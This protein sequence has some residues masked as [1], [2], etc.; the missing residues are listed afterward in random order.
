M[1]DAYAQMQS[2]PNAFYVQPQFSAEH[3]ASSFPA[4]FADPNAYYHQHGMAPATLAPSLAG[5]AG[6]GTSGSSS[7]AGAQ[8]GPGRLKWSR[9]AL[10]ILG[11][12]VV[13]FGVVSL[14]NT[15]KA[16]SDRAH[17]AV[18][19]T[20]NAATGLAAGG[21]GPALKIKPP[22]SA[23]TGIAVTPAGGAHHGSAAARMHRSMARMPGMPGMSGTH[24]RVR[25]RH[26]ALVRGGGAAGGASALGTRRGLRG[27]SATSLPY[28]GA[29]SWVAALIG[30]LALAAGVF[31]QYKALAIGETAAMYRRGPLLRPFWLLALTIRNAPHAAAYVARTMPEVAAAW[32]RAR[33]ALDA[34]GV[35]CDFVSTRRG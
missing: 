35:E 10:L 13:G 11:V 32:L 16:A 28:T 14:I 4:G 31:V 8:A 5:R 27:R 25:G 26:A 3:G 7:M 18:S 21:S 12:A 30:V 2:D 22:A 1:P 19:S 17:A 29:S 9:I 33:A 34:R 23:A 15:N 6:A 20:K 24:M